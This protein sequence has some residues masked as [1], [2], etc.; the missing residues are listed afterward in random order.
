MTKKRITKIAL[1][2][3]TIAIS[4]PMHAQDHPTSEREYDESIRRPIRRLHPERE[5]EKALKE[6]QRQQAAKAAADPWADSGSNDADKPKKA[7]GRKVVRRTTQQ[8]AASDNADK[9]LL[10]ELLSK[11]YSLVQI[12]PDA[13]KPYVWIDEPVE[14]TEPD[15]LKHVDRSAQGAAVRYMPRGA[16]MDNTKNAF[17]LYFDERTEPGPLHLRV[18]YYADDPLN[19]N[20]IDFNIDGFEYTFTPA[21]KHNGRVHGRMIWENS[22]DTMDLDDKDLLYALTHGQWVSISLVGHDGINHVKILSDEQLQA[23]RSVLQLYLLRGG[24]I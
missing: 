5:R 17:Y 18:Q 15:L 6:Y 24:S 13:A 11:D 2:L 1:L 3:F 19:Y 22:D 16:T 20:R 8:P 10:N 7:D 12:V 23:L 9:A 4:P 21:N 14:A